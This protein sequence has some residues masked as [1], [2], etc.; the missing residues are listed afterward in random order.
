MDQEMKTF[1]KRL[2]H[3]TL[4]KTEYKKEAYNFVIAALHYTLD[5]LKESRHITGQELSLGI[6]DYAIEQF[7]CLAQT[8]LAYWGVT[9]TLDF[10][11]IVYTLIEAK[12]M[13][14]TEEDSLEDFRDVYSFD[15]VFRQAIEFDIE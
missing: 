6:S 10:G 7:G 11:N 15:E 2:E 5:K 14:R 9:N 1:I 4:M 12:L 3:V 8:V 13:S